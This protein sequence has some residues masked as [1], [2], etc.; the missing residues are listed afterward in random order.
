MGWRGAKDLTQKKSPPRLLK[1]QQKK[2]S[3][4]NPSS[5]AQKVAAGQKQEGPGSHLAK[6]SKTKVAIVRCES[7]EEK[8]VYEAVK[9]GLGLIGGIGLFAKKGEKILLKVNNLAGDKPEAAVTTH[10]AILNAMIKILLEEGAVVSYGDS[11]GFEKPETGLRKSGFTAVAERFGQGLVKQADF[12]NGK[13]VDFPEGIEWK[14]FDIAN[15]CLECD[16]MISLCKMKTH[17]LARITGAVKNQFGCVHGMHKASFHVKIPNP[18]SFSKMLV[19]LN[20]LLKPRLFIMDGIM[21]MEGNGPR[22]GEPISMNCLIISKDPVAVDSTFCRMVGLDPLY[23]PTIKYGELTGL[24]TYR[25]DR[26]EY[27]GD[28]L[29]SFVNMKFDVVRKPLAGGSLKSLIPKAIRNALYAKPVID[30]AKCIRCGI[31]VNACP[32]EG[33]ALNFKAGEG[34]RKNPPVYDYSK[35]IRCYCCQEMCPQKAI[36]VKGH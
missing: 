22:G 2:T 33:K 36:T 21:A 35:C 11:P 7:Y 34:G 1:E 23:V 3:L 16:G 13:P 12:D 31:C 15:A 19:D 8:T 28:P 10:P 25:L 27:V 32:V 17:Q 26:I 9:R 14:R 4:R 29:E 20:N 5:K 24:G 6:P 30:P 18:I